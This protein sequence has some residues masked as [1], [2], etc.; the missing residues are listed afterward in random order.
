MCGELNPGPLPCEGSVIP[1]HHTPEGTCKQRNSV[2]K[3]VYTGICST[4][5]FMKY[6][7]VKF[8]C[9]QEYKS[10]KKGIGYVRI[11]QI[12]PVYP[13]TIN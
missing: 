3:T 9:N 8:V 5:L 6:K 13:T 4:I 7:G 10:L 11:L 2:F 1:L 12:I